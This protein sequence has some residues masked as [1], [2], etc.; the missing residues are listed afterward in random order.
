MSAARTR[1]AGRLRHS[2]ALSGAPPPVSE[3]EAVAVGDLFRALADPTRLRILALLD[4]G[5]ACVHVI[6]ARL[7]MSQSAVSHQLRLLRVGHLVRPRRAGREIYYTVDD[8]HVA[9][10][11]RDG[12]RHAGCAEGRGGRR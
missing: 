5:E 12:R 8:D 4:E 11:I 2:G 9:Q 1:A 3:R 6:C 7:G 10:L